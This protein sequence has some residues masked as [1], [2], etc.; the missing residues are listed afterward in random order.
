MVFVYLKYHND[1]DRYY[2]G[3]NN[4]DNIQQ[5]IRCASQNINLLK[6]K[7]TPG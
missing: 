6:A 2:G 5:L 4:Q 7:I 1:N 3:E